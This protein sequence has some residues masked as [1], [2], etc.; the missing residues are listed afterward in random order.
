MRQ[1]W[2]IG[3]LP[4]VVM[5]CTNQDQKKTVSALAQVDTTTD[6]PITGP[7]VDVP[8]NIQLDSVIHLAFPKDS[9][10]VT[11]KGHLEK[12][13]KPVICYLPV[14]Q[15]KKLTASIA[16]D[17]VTSNIRFNQIFMPDGQSD[18]P[19]G[20]VLNYKL[21]KKGVYKIYIGS[22][23]MAGNPFTG[24]FALKVKVE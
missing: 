23:L 16:T 2:W 20:K 19:F 5:A 1:T 12:K 11:V 9:Q 17:T 18:G 21:D 4:F 15:G 13:G 24:D 7:A 8:L 6:K 3:V 14:T 10:S 22:S